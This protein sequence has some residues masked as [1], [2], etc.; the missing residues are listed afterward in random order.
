MPE[1]IENIAKSIK[2]HRDLEITI[3]ATKMLLDAH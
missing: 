3:G 1:K 2:R